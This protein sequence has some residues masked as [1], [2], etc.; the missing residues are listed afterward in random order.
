MG[1]I[2]CLVLFRILGIISLSW[3]ILTHLGL[4]DAS[5]TLQDG[6]KMPPR[7]LQDAPRRL[8][9]ALLSLQDASK[10]LQ[11]PPKMRQKTHLGAQ[12]PPRSMFGRC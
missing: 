7:R 11:E 6:P 4:H 5:K 1:F 2:W 8:K 10:P 3:L 12:K 9:I